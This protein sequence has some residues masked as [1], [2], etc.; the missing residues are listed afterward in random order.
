MQRAY[1]ERPRLSHVAAGGKKDEIAK[2]QNEVEEAND[3]VRTPRHPREVLLVP[4]SVH[5][6]RCIATRVPLRI[7]PPSSHGH[8]PL[9]CCGNPC[10]RHVL[11]IEQIEMEVI[12]LPSADRSAAKVGH[13]SRTARL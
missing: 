7:G 12:G 9:P 3:L 4:L 2:A 13:R 10:P 5:R 8:T 6:R 11:Q 1:T